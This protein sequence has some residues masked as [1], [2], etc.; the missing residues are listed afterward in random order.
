MK[1]FGNGKDN[2]G[3]L[4]FI[5][6]PSGRK[7]IS[8]MNDI[9]LNYMFK[10]EKNW[11]V[12]RTLVN[13]LIAE[14]KEFSSSTRISEISGPVTVETQYLYYI[15][16]EGKTKRQD[17]K[18]ISKDTT[19]IEF[20]NNAYPDPPIKV[21]ALE[22]FGLGIGYNGGQISNQ[23]WIMA[24]DNE[25]LMFGNAF[26]DFVLIDEFTGKPYPSLSGIMFSSL[27]KLSEKVGEVGDLARFLLGKQKESVSE[28]V[29]GIINSFN[30]SFEKFKAE[31]EVL[32][33][34]TYAE[35][36]RL[37]GIL[38]GEQK[39]R[40]EGLL[41]GKMEMAVGMLKL[42]YVPDVDIINIAEISVEQLDELKK[43]VALNN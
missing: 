40:L 29:S 37:E 34:M 28:N 25:E 22:Y 17:I 33:V 27:K 11:E 32:E 7:S 14:Y 15:N 24:E 20:Q 6:L 23:L 30:N 8:P 41:E 10:D 35:Q 21:R 12:L 9:F 13:I 19:F 42:G 2:S 4:G 38:E 36:V 16:P 26:S 39:G 31:K 43:Q 3:V 1:A 5:E 18:M